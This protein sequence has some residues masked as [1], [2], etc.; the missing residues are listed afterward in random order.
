M[1]G[2]F[3]P[4]T[5]KTFTDKMASFHSYVFENKPSII[6]VN[7]T[8]FTNEIHDNEILPNNSY[9]IYRLDRSLKT[10]PYDENN[11]KKF[12]KNGGGIMIAIRS[13]L[14]VDSKAIK[15]KNFDCKAEILSVDIKFPDGTHKCITTVY[16]VG[17]LKDE[18]HAQIDSYL[19]KLATRKNIGKITLVGDLNL[20]SIKWPEGVS[21][22]ALEN[23]FL[24]SFNDIGF[25][26]LVSDATHE[27]GRT[28]DLILSNTI[29]DVANIKI[30]NKNTVCSSDHFAIEFTLNI[31]VKRKKFPKRKIFNFKKAK[32]DKLNKE[33]NSINWSYEFRNS[34]LESNW[35]IFKSIFFKLCYKHIPMVTVG[36]K[37]QPPW[38]DSETYHL[39]RE[40]E[41][42]RSNFKKSKNLIDYEKFI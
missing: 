17:S 16:R 22:C 3:N 26:Q 2:L 28:L 21:T 37:M 8:W 29:N 41:R 25:T 13:D 11:P 6:V 33:L 5:L 7:E 32:W 31:K 35:K 12:R 23:K 42:H 14:N 19:K 39:C 18:N 30:L 38:F 27:E 15:F 40:K 9:K 4:L 34:G 36:S 10:H 20:S 24:N 1:R